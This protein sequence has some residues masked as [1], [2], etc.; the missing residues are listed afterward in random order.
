MVF[1]GISHFP[2]IRFFGDIPY[3][4]IYERKKGDVLE[5][6]KNDNFLLTYITYSD[7][8]ESQIVIHGGEI[9]IEKRILE[10]ALCRVVVKNLELEEK[11]KEAEERTTLWRRLWRAERM[12]K[13]EGHA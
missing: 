2:G 13:N 7:N 9:M 1:H 4:N 12:D 5:K 3:K 11:L 8:I 10:Q 6:G